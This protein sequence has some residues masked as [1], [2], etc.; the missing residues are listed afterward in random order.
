MLELHFGFVYHGAGRLSI[1]PPARLQVTPHQVTPIIGWYPFI[2]LAGQRYCDWKNAKQHPQPVLKPRLFDLES[3]ALIIGPTCLIKIL[4]E[5]MLLFFYYSS[6]FL[7]VSSV[8][9]S[10][11]AIKHNANALGK[12][13]LK[14]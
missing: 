7:W 5:C 8:H 6:F 13:Q 3:S 1:P 14:L 4:R 9:L 11:N 10:V 12:L 2:L